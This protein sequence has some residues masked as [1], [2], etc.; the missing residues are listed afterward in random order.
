VA[1]DESLCLGAISYKI[2]DTLR[3]KEVTR[4]T[5]TVQCVQFI[6]MATSICYSTE[7]ECHQNLQTQA[8]TQTVPLIRS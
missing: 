1:S 6:L 7:C 8:Q 2:Y 4:I 3:E 5:P